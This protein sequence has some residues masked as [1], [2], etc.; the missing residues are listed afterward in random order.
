MPKISIEIPQETNKIIIKHPEI[1]WNKL[2]SA[3]LW[4]YAKKIMFLD[5]MSSKSK[6]TTKDVETLDHAIK[7]DILKKYQTA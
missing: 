6:L 4:S 7:T 1:D 3:T 2:I 5:S